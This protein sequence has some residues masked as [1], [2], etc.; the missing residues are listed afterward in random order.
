MA[1]PEQQKFATQIDANQ[2]ALIARLA[3]AVAIP[4]VSGDARYRKAC[5]DM[6]DWLLA[7]LTKLGAKGEL[8]P[9]GK[10]NLEGQ[11]IELPPVILAD[12]GN[13]PKKK[14]ILVYGHYDVQPALKSDGWEH[15]PFKL[16]FDEKSGRMYG[17]GSTDDKGPILGWINV[18]E[19]HQQVG[20]DLPVNLKICFEGME[21]SGSVGL[22]D[23]VEKEKD[24]FFKGIDAICI[25]DNYWLGTKKPCLT[26]GLRGIQYFKLAINGPGA[27]L[28]SGVFGGVVHEPMTDLFAIMS[29]LVTPQGKILIPG[30]NELVAPLTDEEKKRYDVMEFQISDIDEATGSQTAISDE[31]QQ[32]LMGRM[33]YPSLSLHGIEGAFSEPGTKTVIPSRVVGK[34]SVRLVPDMTP[35]KVVEVVE[36]Y[37]NEEWKK[38]GSKNTMRLDAEPGGKPWLADPNHYNYRAASKATET[39][40]GVKPDLTR[41]GGSI[42]VSLTFSEILG[43]NLLLLPMGR[44][45]DGA[46][47]INEKL[48]ISNY[49]KGTQLLGLYLHEVANAA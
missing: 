41:E 22:D 31:K 37:I 3:E 40:Y 5:F 17:R 48:D 13:D 29:K 8:R 6:A 34:F 18:I 49:I 16:T 9:L 23:L 4:S 1:T 27:D 30:I 42:P 26:H 10:Q 21:E 11:Q 45:N 28:H 36:K 2:Q 44:S 24:A 25:S 32:V 47:S 7:S 20:V 14:T 39:V 43:K 46:H 15:E 12:Y 19:A 35:E 38:L 33:R